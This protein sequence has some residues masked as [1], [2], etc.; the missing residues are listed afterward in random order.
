LEVHEVIHWGQTLAQSCEYEGRAL[1]YNNNQIF[2][3]V[4]IIKDAMMWGPVA[5][6]NV[7][8]KLMCYIAAKQ[9]AAQI[10]RNLGK[11]MPGS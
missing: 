5:Y 10:T 6:N 9:R 4:I 2:F 8:L 1:P 3:H 7:T 11:S